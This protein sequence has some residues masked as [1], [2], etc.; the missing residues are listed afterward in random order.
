MII[1]DNVADELVA[2][3]YNNR[4]AH[5]SHTL[6]DNPGLGCIALEYIKAYEGQ[7]NEVGNDK[8]PP[9]SSFVDTFAP[10]CGVKAATLA[11]ITGRLLA[12]QSK[13]VSPAEAFSNVLIYN[14]KSL[15]ILYDKNHTQIGAAVSGT[16]GGAPYFWCVLFS[17]GKT[18]NSFTF[19]G[20]V[21][22]NVRPGC[23]S[24]NND[25][26]SN[27]MRPAGSLFLPAITG[28]LLVL[29]YAFGL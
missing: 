10:N 11:P 2:V 8:K 18:N 20:G 17:S 27:A 4:T 6:F 24:G 28:V 19:D 22:K 3:I 16:D 12:C 15:Q 29:I 26:C 25:D 23:F 21:A 9:D 13:Y 5:K 7:C 1:E 14:A